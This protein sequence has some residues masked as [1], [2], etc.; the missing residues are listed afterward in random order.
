[1]DDYE[2]TELPRASTALFVTSTMGQGDPPANMKRFWR[3]LLR[4]S[5]PAASLAGVDFA[6]FG[7]GDSH[8]KKYNVAA[9]RLHKRLLR[10]VLSRT[11]SH[12]IALAW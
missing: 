5:L 9:K 4:K 11:G 6:V 7:L 10:C 1:M 8:Y 3:F 2:V 12:T